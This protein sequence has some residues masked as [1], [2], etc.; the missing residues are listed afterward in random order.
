MEPLIPSVA[1]AQSGVAYLKGRARI[2]LSGATQNTHLSVFS[3]GRVNAVNQGLFKDTVT[4]DGRADIAYIAILSAD[5]KFGG[6]RT[7]NA[8]YSAT[9][10]ITGIHAPGV[11]FTGPVFASDIDA[12]GTATPVMLLGSG[13]DV[14]ITGGDLVQTNGRAVQISGVAQL[15]FRNG[16]TSHGTI[17]PA[18]SIGGQLEENGANA[19]ARIALPPAP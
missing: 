1:G 11:Q 9:Q 15:Q 16:S 5:G 8:V 6:L 4:Y 10:G 14:R 7:A 19:T 18:Q 17:L 13:G 2:V 12:A 3:V